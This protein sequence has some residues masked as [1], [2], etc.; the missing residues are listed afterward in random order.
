ML[1]IRRELSEQILLLFL[2]V[3]CPG[4]RVPPIIYHSNIF[5]RQSLQVLSDLKLADINFASIR[6]RGRSGV[7]SD[8]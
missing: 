2:L 5:A 4:S 1:I 8:S 3:H 7:A 6:N